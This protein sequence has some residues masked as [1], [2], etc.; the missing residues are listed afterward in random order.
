MSD[1]AAREAHAPGEFSLIGRDAQRR[2][3]RIE[4]AQA[5]EG[6]PT[7]R[8][9]PAAEMVMRTPTSV[10]APRT[11]WT[12]LGGRCPECERTPKRIE[13][14]LAFEVDPVAPGP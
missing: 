2:L 14:L 1:R 6:C 12:S 5:L 8:S 10:V 11:G 4:S 3:S 13:L 7:C 9:L